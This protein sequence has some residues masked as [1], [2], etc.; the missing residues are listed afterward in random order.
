MS[1]KK[2]EYTK[3]QINCLAVLKGIQQALKKNLLSTKFPM[4]KKVELVKEDV[5]LFL[6]YGV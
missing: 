4:V 2:K 6:D 5:C 3:E 1:R